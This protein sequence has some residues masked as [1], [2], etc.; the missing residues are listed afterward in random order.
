MYTTFSSDVKKEEQD[1]L[2]KDETELKILSY[3][4]ST[5][6]NVGMFTTLSLATLAAAHGHAIQ[7]NPWGGYARYAASIVFLGLAVFIALK[8]ID[9]REKHID[10]N[11]PLGPW[12][13]VTLSV[14]ISQ[15]IIFIAIILSF[16]NKM[17]L[18]H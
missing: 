5:L 15:T 10:L 17:I 13:P 12:E 4:Q 7:K 2:R 18:K 3:Y 1:Q 11:D 8:L 6:R 14:L 9:V 16:V